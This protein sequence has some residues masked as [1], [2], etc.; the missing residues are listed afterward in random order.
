MT[1][2]WHKQG[3]YTLDT[4][5]FTPT[6][7]PRGYLG[8]TFDP[9]MWFLDWGKLDYPRKTQRYRENMQTSHFTH[10]FREAVKRL[11]VIDHSFNPLQHFNWLFKTSF[12]LALDHMFAHG[13]T[14]CW[15]SAVYV[16]VHNV[17]II[18]Y[19]SSTDT[20]INCVIVGSTVRSTVVNY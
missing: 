20:R 12:S 11:S 4:H 10:N 13:E 2:H 5:T 1:A 7:T 18:L 9:N 6:L 14:Q 19:M 16:L 15:K 3:I 8:S 17:F